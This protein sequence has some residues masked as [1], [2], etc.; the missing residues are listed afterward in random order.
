MKQHAVAEGMQAVFTRK[1]WAVVHSCATL[2][3]E[4]GIEGEEGRAALSRLCVGGQVTACRA[5]RQC[6]TQAAIRTPSL[7]PH[8]LGM[9]RMLAWLGP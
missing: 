9:M 6:Q 5:L 3:E 8:F 4:A 7:C 1:Y 2:N